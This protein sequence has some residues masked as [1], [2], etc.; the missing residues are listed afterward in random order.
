MGSNHWVGSNSIGS[1]VDENLKV[2][3]TDNLFVVDA[4]IVSLS[5]HSFESR[6]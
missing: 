4:S 1:V 5:Q 2:M 6:Y 3:Q